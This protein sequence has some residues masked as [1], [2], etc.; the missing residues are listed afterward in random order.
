LQRGFGVVSAI[1]LMVVLAAIGVAMV[2]LSATQH[3]GLAVDVQGARAYQAARA[4]VEWGLY[5]ALIG[6]PSSACPAS[7][8]FVPAAPTLNSF[9]VT[10]KCTQT[11][12]SN[13]SPPIIIRQLEVTACNQPSSGACPGANRNSDYVER[14]LQATF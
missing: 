5:Q 12:D 1:F 11:S 7:T 8:S 10:V 2:N 4:G 3:I 9:T 6:N 13:E 14:R